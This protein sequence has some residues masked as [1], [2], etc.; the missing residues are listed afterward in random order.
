MQMIF[1]DSPTVEYCGESVQYS[2][3][4]SWL[5]NRAAEQHGFNWPSFPCKR[6]GYEFCSK[7]V[8]RSFVRDQR[9]GDAEDGYTT[10]KIFNVKYQEFRAFPDHIEV[11]EG[12]TEETEGASNVSEPSEAGYG[13]EYG[14]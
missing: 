8:G 13:A 6:D 11:W 9:R 14:Y 7:E 4:K 1:S 12:W 10:V 2:G 5:V 3:K